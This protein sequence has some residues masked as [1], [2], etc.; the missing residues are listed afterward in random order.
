MADLAHG[1]GNE[2]KKRRECDLVTLGL[3]VTQGKRRVCAFFYH[4]GPF[5]Q[6]LDERPI[7]EGG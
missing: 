3:G 4:W 5:R 6:C 7:K 2:K 1:G